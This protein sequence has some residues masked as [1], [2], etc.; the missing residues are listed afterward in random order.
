[1]VSPA[2]VIVNAVFENAVVPINPVPMPWNVKTI[3]DPDTLSSV[4]IATAMI[5]IKN[6]ATG[7]FM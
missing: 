4:V 1:M 3:G 7:P 5:A 6:G 2:A